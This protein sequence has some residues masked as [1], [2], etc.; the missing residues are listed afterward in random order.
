MTRGVIDAA[1]EQSV[2]RWMRIDG[3]EAHDVGNLA[4][5]WRA[6]ESAADRARITAFW[7]GHHC[8]VLATAGL[9]TLGVG[10]RLQR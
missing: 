3:W 8:P 7:L 10:H 4:A 2:P 1:Q 9:A 5:R 6:L